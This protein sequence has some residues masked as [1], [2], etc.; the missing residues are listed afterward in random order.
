M[1]FVKGTVAFKAEIDRENLSC[2]TV[3]G[4]KYEHAFEPAQKYKEGKTIIELVHMFKDN[5]WN[6]SPTRV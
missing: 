3:L 5:G 1:Y 2:N 6:S 4:W